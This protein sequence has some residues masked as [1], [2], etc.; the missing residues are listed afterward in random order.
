M[1]LDG[2]LLCP[3]ERKAELEA[4][5]GAEQLAYI[6]DLLDRGAKQL[7]ESHV[8]GLQAIAVRDIYPCAGSYRHARI[9]DTPHAD[10]VRRGGGQA[11]GAS[12]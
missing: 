10:S 3:F 4:R 2:P 12:E 7:R 8:L 11:E 6:V 5:N 1:T 9:L